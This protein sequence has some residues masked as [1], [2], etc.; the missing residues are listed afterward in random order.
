MATC[1]TAA[2]V[3]LPSNDFMAVRAIAGRT[4]GVDL[5]ENWLRAAG[6]CESRQHTVDDVSVSLH[7]DL[8]VATVLWTD[9][10]DLTPS[11]SQTWNSRRMAMHLSTRHT[12]GL[13]FADLK[14]GASDAA[15]PS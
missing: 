5:K 7:G 12:R 2:C 8:A 1:D 14:G 4:L 13:H 10:D 3:E 11:S 6:A 15:T 9:G